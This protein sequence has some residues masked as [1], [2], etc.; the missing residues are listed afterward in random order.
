VHGD[1]ILNAEMPKAAIGMLFRVMKDE[2]RPD[3]HVDGA[4]WRL[5]ADLF[6]DNGKDEIKLWGKTTVIHVDEFGKAIMRTP[7]TVNK[8][9]HEGKIIISSLYHPGLLAISFMHCK[10]VTVVDN[11]V[12]KPLAKK[13][14]AKHNGLRPTKYKTLVIEPL[15]EILRREGKSDQHGIA[16]AMHICRG[17]FADYREGKG[18]FGKY[19]QVVWIPQVVKGKKK[20]EEDEVPPRE[21]VIKLGSFGQ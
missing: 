1:V 3:V 14:A 4:K 6:L 15:K 8:T 16:K 5:A 19:H 13:Y 7:V 10:N 11:V 9:P 17:H 2:H 20:H 21:A 12:P 18:L